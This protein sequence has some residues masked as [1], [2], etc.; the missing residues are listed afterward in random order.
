MVCL[1]NALM[2]INKKVKL[3][4]NE[5]LPILALLYIMLYI[6]LAYLMMFAALS[7]AACKC[8]FF[9]FLLIFANVLC[10]HTLSWFID[11]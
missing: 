9:F 5:C 4:N 1:K 2:R 7:N 6:L 11:T 10:F 8:L 3:I